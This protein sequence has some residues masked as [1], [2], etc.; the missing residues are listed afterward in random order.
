[1]L[2]TGPILSFCAFMLNS[3]A[4]RYCDCC[5][6]PKKSKL[7]V[8]IS[9]L[10]ITVFH[11]NYSQRA[12]HQMVTKKM[13]LCKQVNKESKWTKKLAKKHTLW[14]R[15]IVHPT[16]PLYIQLLVIDHSLFWYRTKDDV[17]I[18][19]ICELV[20]RI[21]TAIFIHIYDGRTDSPTYRDAKT[22][23]ENWKPI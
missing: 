4:V 20:Q 9:L 6:S 21:F 12:Y 15:W 17:E 22:H 3:G 16:L 18:S 11:W 23:K 13:N 10:L 19:S 2:H 1:M 14:L 7:C 8:I 5:R